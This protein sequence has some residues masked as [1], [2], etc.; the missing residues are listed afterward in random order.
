M[1]YRVVTYSGESFSLTEDQCE[2]VAN[3]LVHSDSKFITMPSKNIIAIND[4][5]YCG[6][7][8]EA[9][10]VKN[11]NFVPA[12]QKRLESPQQDI[13]YL[14]MAEFIKTGEIKTGSEEY[15]LKMK[16][17][18]LEHV[19]RRPAINTTMKDKRLEAW[20]QHL[21]R[22]TLEEQKIMRMPNG[23]M[24]PEYNENEMHIINTPME[25]LL[26]T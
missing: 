4:I 7:M 15:R 11:E 12:E 19:K 25:E 5:K 9:P 1:H 13:G 2:K 22:Y 18:W 17:I 10:I 26:K 21:S 3:A 16:K 20:Q 14:P 24:E 23:Y 8:N 6:H